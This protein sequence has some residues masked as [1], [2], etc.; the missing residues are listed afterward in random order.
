MKQLRSGLVIKLI[1]V[2]ANKSFLVRNPKAK[3]TLHSIM[4]VK[5]NAIAKSTKATNAMKATQLSNKMQ[6]DLLAL[7]SMLMSPSQYQP[8]YKSQNNSNHCNYKPQ[9]IW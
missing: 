9:T 2:T 7:F 8:A 3:T 5:D 6:N 1:P 4:I